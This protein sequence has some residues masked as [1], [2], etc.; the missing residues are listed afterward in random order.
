M[1][2]TLAVIGLIIFAVYLCSR[3]LPPKSYHVVTHKEATLT[4]TAENIEMVDIENT[5]IGKTSPLTKNEPIKTGITHHK[6]MHN[7]FAVETNSRN[8]CIEKLKAEHKNEDNIEESLSYCK[9]GLAMARATERFMKSRKQPQLSPK[10]RIS[11]LP[12]IDLTPIRPNHMYPEVASQEMT[13]ANFEGTAYVKKAPSRYEQLARVPAASSGA[14][15][16]GIEGEA[17]RAKPI[18]EP[19]E[20]SAPADEPTSTNVVGPSQVIPGNAEWPTKVS[21]PEQFSERELGDIPTLGSNAQNAFDAAAGSEI[22]GAEVPSALFE[23]QAHYQLPNTGAVAGPL[24]SRT[25]DLRRNQSKELHQSLQTQ[26]ST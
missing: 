2:N 18:N 11:R 24:N 21:R 6:P 8:P 14:R 7:H 16:I 19:N 15:E 25:M 26:A 1:K 23:V 12:A 4:S 3:E 20:K 22:Y 17:N 9:R 5:N 10:D 13:T